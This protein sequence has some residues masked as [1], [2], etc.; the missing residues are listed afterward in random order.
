MTSTHDLRAKFLANREQVRSWLDAW[1]I[2]EIAWTDEFDE[3]PAPWAVIER[4]RKRWLK[5]HAPHLDVYHWMFV[6]RPLTPGVRTVRALWHFGSGHRFEKLDVTITSVCDP[7][8]L[9]EK[10]TL[11]V[12]RAAL[13]G[14]QEEDAQPVYQWLVEGVN[15][16]PLDNAVRGNKRLGFVLLHFTRF[17][18][19]DGDVVVSVTAV[20]T[21]R[22]MDGSLLDANG[23]SIP[24]AP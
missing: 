12:H 11:A 10:L 20:E 21:D 24:P 22:A 13:K 5:D 9:A 23:V 15:T 1:E 4:D 19:S 17:P 7:G 18:T 2:P 8:Y 16:R 14:W 6:G 3:I